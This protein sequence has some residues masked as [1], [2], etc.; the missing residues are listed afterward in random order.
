MEGPLEIGVRL[1]LHLEGVDVLS[2]NA[3]RFVGASVTDNL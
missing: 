1:A 3:P 2:D